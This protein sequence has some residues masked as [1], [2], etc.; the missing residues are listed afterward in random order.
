MTGTSAASA[1]R[2]H[3]IAVLL[4]GEARHIIGGPVPRA[5]QFRRRLQGAALSGSTDGIQSVGS[6]DILPQ[7]VELRSRMKP[8]AA[9]PAPAA[10]GRA[11]APAHA[12]GATSASLSIVAL[13]EDPMLLEAL[14]LAAI[15]QP[16]VVSSPSADRFADQLV[17]NTAAVARIDAVVAH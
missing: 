17:A 8:R 2:R 11:A 16:D 9:P 7:T 6:G 4:T 3:S 10:A 12:A 1:A 15:D 13:S 5:S 14:T